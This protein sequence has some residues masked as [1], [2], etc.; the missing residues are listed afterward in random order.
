MKHRGAISRGALLPKPRVAE[1]WLDDAKLPGLN[2]GHG[3]AVDGCVYYWLSLSERKLCSTVQ[4]GA[5]DV[6]SLLTRCLV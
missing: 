2:N 1:P 6:E 3:V 5:L 4:F